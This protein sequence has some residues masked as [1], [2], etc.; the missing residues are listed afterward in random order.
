LEA[1][2]GGILTVTLGRRLAGHLN[3]Y[4]LGWVGI[5]FGAGGLGWLTVRQLTAWI[6][7]EDA[8][9]GQSASGGIGWMLLIFALLLLAGGGI[10]YLGRRK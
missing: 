10:L 1:V 3:W 8:M 6:L 2:V 5:L 7:G 9:M 4:H